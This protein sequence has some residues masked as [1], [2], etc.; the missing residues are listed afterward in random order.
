MTAVGRGIVVRLLA[1]PPGVRG[2]LWMLFSIASF[3]G[4][5]ISGRELSTEMSTVEVLFFRSLVG[6]LVMLPLVIGDSGLATARKGYHFTRNIVHFSGQVGWFYGVAMLPLADLTALSGTVP[7]FGAVIALIVLKERVGLRRAAV[8]ALGF[9][10]VLVM[11]RPGFAEVGLP[12]FAVLF[13]SAMYAA[14]SIMVKIMTRTDNARIVVFYMQIMQLPMA[15][16]PAL[17]FWTTPGWAD[18]P[19]IVGVGVCGL[20]AHYFMARALTI[21]DASVVMPMSFLQL[22]VMAALGYL[23]YAEIPDAWMLVGG[24]M[25]L[26]GTWWNMRAEAARS[27]S[28]V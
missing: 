3:V 12:A 6:A 14:A 4:M 24:G 1:I 26:A 13:G 27:R 15:L 23:L 18:L 20:G 16:L 7:I 22:P 28:G 17:F 2:C 19:A 10:G 11:L 25:V 8:I 9:S 21:A 5:T